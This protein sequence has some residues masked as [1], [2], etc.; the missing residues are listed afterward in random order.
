MA[1]L[2]TFYLLAFF[3]GFVLAAIFVVW[4]LGMRL[5]DH[6]HGSDLRI[7]WYLFSLSSVCTLMAAAWAS[8]V[9]AIDQSGSFQGNSGKTI[10]SF[11]K[12][13]L[14]LDT[15]IKLFATLLAVFVVPQVTSYVLSGLFG[16]ASSPILIGRAFALFVWSI[17]KSFVVASGILL[18][19]AVYGAVKGWVSWT[20]TGAASMSFFSLSLLMLS[21]GSLHL[22]RDIGNTTVLP[23][24]N[25][26]L[27]LRRCLS[28]VRAWLIRKEIKSGDAS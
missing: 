11:L 17:V 26:G 20:L 16:C 27:R 24:S 7:V 13:M 2:S 3:T 14:D 25:R 22:Y 12:F 1:N 15:D 9:G 10:E 6:G 4:C 23:N 21:F 28:S 18:T 5:A 8:S 19:I